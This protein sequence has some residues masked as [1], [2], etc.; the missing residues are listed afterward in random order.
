MNSLLIQAAFKRRPSLFLII[1]TVI[2]FISVLCLVFEPRWETN[3]DVGMAMIAH[4]YGI[5]AYGT[6][7]IMFSNVLWGHFVRAIPEINGV[8]G[9]SLATLTVLAVVGIVLVVGL[10]NSGESLLVAVLC[11]ILA[12]T[13]PVLFPQFTVIAGL[14]VVAAVVFWNIWAQVKKNSLLVVGCLLAWCGFLIRSYE[15]LLVLFVSLPLLPWREFLNCRIAKASMT[16]LLF[17]ILIAG[18]LD[19][20]AYQGEE[21]REFT[22]LNKPRAA[23]TDYGVATRLKAQPDTLERYGYSQNDIDLVASWFFVDTKI[24][25]PTKLQA[26]LDQLGS[27]YTEVR[28]WKNAW[29]GIVGFSSHILLP[30]ILAALLLSMLQLNRKLLACWGLCLGAMAVIGFMGRPGILRVYQPLTTLLL[31]APFLLRS[32]I[33]CLAD[34]LKWARIGTL[35]VAACACVYLVFTESKASQAEA[36]LASVKFSNFPETTLVVWGAAFPYEL[37]YPVLKIEPKIKAIK[38]YGLGTSTWAPFSIAY[39]ETKAGRSLS[40]ELLKASGVDL[41]Q[42]GHLD[43]LRLYCIEHHD[44][45]LIT[46]LRNNASES[47]ENFGN[48]TCQKIQPQ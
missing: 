5:A 25:N 45:A 46:R 12:L 33:V 24:A 1:T 29:L 47:L 30:S 48:Y 16:V 7:N 11:M 40:T 28:S 44:G 19:W 8:S 35:F 42:V 27:V 38:H 4:G 37:L 20:Q 2:A 14:A 18:A 22:A 21:W 31:I 23:F 10:I 34:T 17:A 43:K 39:S 41:L 3:D 9:Y 36:E 26:M 6:P 15:F 13:R 32:K